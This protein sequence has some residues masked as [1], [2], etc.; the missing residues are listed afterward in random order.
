MKP[1]FALSLSF[2]GIRLLHRAAGGWRVVGDVALDAEDMAAELAMLRKTATSLEPG[3]LR[4]KLLIPNE[5][6]KYLTIDTPDQSPDARRMAAQTALDGATPYAVADLVFDISIDGPRTHV[7]AVAQ[8]T[9]AE[10]EA[11]A[12]EHRFHPVCFAAVPDDQPYLGAPYFGATK[13]APDLLDAGDDVEPDDVAVVVIGDAI[14]PPPVPA[15]ETPAAEALVAEAPA[16]AQIKAPEE[17]PPVTKPD[18][19]KP[20]VATPKVETRPE[21][22]AAPISEPQPA[23]TDTAQT[24]PAPA[25]AKPAP[26]AGPPKP[27][28]PN[29]PQTGQQPPAHAKATPIGP[30]APMASSAAPATPPVGFASRRSTDLPASDAP[31]SLGGQRRDDLPAPA[32]TAAPMAPKPP[33]SD[34]PGTEADVNS[35]TMQPDSTS[36]APVASSAA[37]GFLSRRKPKP[38]GRGTS[39]QPKSKAATGRAPA[40]EAE[41]MTVFGAR[42]STDVRGKPRFLGLILTAALLVFLAG[43]AA[44]ASIFLDDGMSLSRLFGDRSPRVTASGPTAVD[45]QPSIDAPAD[46]DIEIASLEPDLT[47]EDGAVLDALRVPDAPLPLPQLTEDEIEARYAATGIFPRAP[48]VP[49][50]PAG[51][52]DIEDLYLTSIDPVSTSTDAVALP[53]VDGFVTDVAPGNV[54]SPPAAGTQFTLDARG[55]VIPTAAGA[56]SPDGFTVFLGRPE[57]VPPATMTRPE[58]GEAVAE[59]TPEAPNPLAK[60]RPRNRPN[61]LAETTERAQLD[62]LTKVEL[63]GFRPAIRPRSVQ[64]EA[65]VTE[66]AAVEAPLATVDTSAAVAAALAT[67][68]AFEN[69]TKLAATASRRP[70]VRPRNFARIVKRAE[71]S[72]PAPAPDTRVASAAIVAPRT[73]TP[74]IPSTASVAKQATVKNAIN[75]RQVNLIGVYGKPSSRRALVRL[76][77]GRYEKVAVGDRLDGGRVSAIGDKELVYVKRGRNVVLQMPKS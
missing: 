22:T 37:G 17:Q 34:G 51:L 30:S 40:N 70:D 43:V 23:K 14:L 73:V 58:G 20:D 52:V 6:I 75:L 11:F 16:A 27:A 71:R 62:G 53:A 48:D 18:I 74:S 46:D 25:T 50:E 2:Q 45:P 35:G 3:G 65:A 13:A 1:N 7:A 63:A 69:A 47:D 59:E 26:V 9:L 44:W 36:L 49:P 61:D 5:Q 8:E 72:A 10:A 57:V 29:A 54:A 42:R 28:Q 64:E 21:P 33:A 32:G 55:L 12:M 67:P 41:R 66:V 19:T 38:T 56:P 31:R 39:D 68:Q 77:N 76:S 15:A 4:S 60:L 24:A